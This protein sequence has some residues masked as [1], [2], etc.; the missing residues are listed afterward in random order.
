MSEILVEHARPGVV[1]IRLDAPSRRN[2]L[3]GDMARDFVAACRAVKA[4]PEV[5]A[6][7]IT[8]GPVAFCAGADRA[9]LSAVASGDPDAEADLLA[10]YEMFDVLRDLRVPTIAAVCGAAVGAGLNLAL[11][12]SLRVAGENA[13]LE[14]GF[15]RNGIHPAGGHLRMLR[16]IGGRA[17]AVRMAVLDEP[18]TAEQAT[19]AGLVLGSCAADRAEAWAVEL[20]TRAGQNPALARWITESVDAVAGLGEADAA[21]LE[22]DA[23]RRSL[24]LREASA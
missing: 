16:G 5:G 1:V 10:V 2:A 15:V 9:L 8:G 23:Q 19:A 11:A 14:S 24:A 3:R 7:V 17:L 21:Q 4:S 22:A 6:A 12:C 13:R 18:L 20:A